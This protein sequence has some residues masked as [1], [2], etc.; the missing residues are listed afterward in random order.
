M[1][2]RKNNPELVDELIERRWEMDLGEFE[3]K[4]STLSSS[5]K[6]QV[7]LATD[8]DW[9]D[10][11]DFACDACGNPAYPDCKSSCPLFDD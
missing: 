8:D 5:D 10:D 1:G 9:G 7:D 2:R 6:E 3:M 4:Y 11:S